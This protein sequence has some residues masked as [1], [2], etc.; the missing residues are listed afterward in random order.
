[1]GSAAAKKRV[2]TTTTT[3][4]TITTA[5]PMIVGGATIVTGL[6]ATALGGRQI[7]I[8]TNG[9]GEKR[10][11]GGNVKLT[12]VVVKM[13]ASASGRFAISTSAKCA[14]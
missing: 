7:E 5:T 13:T 12:F 14:A 10:T 8:A 11:H 3:T 1:M 4:I 9:D 6:G 2:E